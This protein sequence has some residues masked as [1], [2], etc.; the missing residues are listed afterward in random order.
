ML[1]FK[2]FAQFFSQFW[3]EVA[4]IVLFTEIPVTFS[5]FSLS[6]VAYL[7]YLLFSFF[8][9]C[10]ASQLPSHFSVCSLFFTFVQFESLPLAIFIS[11]G[12]LDFRRI[13]I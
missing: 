6:V 2:T 3:S 12:S 9:A 11:E 4:Y 10:C 5:T 8:D 13:S 1:C 7:F